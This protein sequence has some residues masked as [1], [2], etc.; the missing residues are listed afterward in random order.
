MSKKL[1]QKW[2]VK[3]APLFCWF[4]GKG[5]G[6][7]AALVVTRR[8][9]GICN[10]CIAVCVQIQSKHLQELWERLHPTGFHPSLEVGQPDA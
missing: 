10:D 6:E 1:Q 7:T 5:I 4:C 2:P 8:D 9:I 3:G